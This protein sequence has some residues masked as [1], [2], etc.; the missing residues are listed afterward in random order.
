[1][2]TENN[3][4]LIHKAFFDMAEKY[5]ERTAVVQRTENGSLQNFT[6]H[7]IADKAKRYCTLLSKS[8]EQGIIGA[9]LDKSAEFISAVMGILASGRAYLPISAS[10]PTERRKYILEK[11]D[12]KTVI[13]SEED[14]DYFETLGLQVFTPEDAETDTISDTKDTDPQNDAY[15]IF[16]SGTTGQPKGVEIQHYA[17][18]NTICDINKRF[19]VNS[20]DTAFAVSEID[21]DLSVYDIFGLLSV[22]GK[23]VICDKT[24]KKEAEQWKNLM[25]LEKVTVWNSVPML[26]DMLLSADDKNEVVSNLRL[27][28]LSG[29]WVYPSLIERI[30][31]KNKTARIIALGGATEASIWSN[32][33]EVGADLDISLQSVP[34]GLPLTNQEYRIVGENGVITSAGEAGELQIGGLGLAKGYVNAPEL[35]AER[36]ITENGSRWY[37][38]GDKGRYLPDGNIEFLGRLDNQV[39]FGGYRIELDEI[40]KNLIS[41][42]RISNAGTVMLQKQTKQVLASVIVEKVEP[43]G[44]AP[45][46]TGEMTDFS[47]ICSQQVKT[48]CAALM[49]ILGIHQADMFTVDADE[50]F[51]RLNY[52]EQNRPVYD[53]WLFVLEQQGFIRRNGNVIE[54]AEKTVSDVPAEMNNSIELLCGVM[55]GENTTADMLQDEWLSPEMMSV[56]EKG[57][58]DGV[59]EIAERI[60]EKYDEEEMNL[61][62]AV[63]GVRTGIV[64]QMLIEQTSDSDIDFTFI[65]QSAFFTSQARE[66]LGSEHNYRVIKDSIPDDLRNAFDIVININD[67]HT[68]PDYEQ[69]VFHIRELLKNK[70]C[71]YVVDL[72]ALP[73]LSYLS[74][75]KMENGFVNF[76]EENR[77]ERFNPVMPADL[78]SEYYIRQGFCH[79]K[80]HCYAD[81]LFT[82]L[83]AE[84]FTSDEPLTANA[85]R[86]YLGQRVPEYM[87]PEKIVFA[88]RIPLTPNGKPDRQSLLN[89]V[90]TDDLSD[91][92]PPSTETE[93]KLAVMWKDILHTNEVGTEQSFFRSGGDS[94]LATHLLT[95]VRQEFNVEFSLK[96][97]YSDP[98][99]SA[100]AELIDRKIS[101]FDDEDIEFGEI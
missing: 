98:T 39:K 81:S 68:H 94:L 56:N 89:A 73:P 27:I 11:A 18:Y 57:I 21:F 12:V 93:K 79:V 84:K 77:P 6:Y 85:I 80:W 15:I 52:E 37:R 20:Q 9:V 75:A 5:P 64:A 99:L 50:L 87:I 46:R 86:Y 60:N 30:R 29:D 69:E 58:R 34:Y 90:N 91:L 95:R 88:H 36:F 23:I 31:Q 44:E 96:E 26:F 32:C 61:H 16:T 10:V 70:G 76:T 48:V 53:Y 63:I 66:R 38:T 78:A 54:S 62:I 24:M 55:R 19:E 65:D 42:E 67:M 25:K 3:A 59:A 7:E 82:M 13:T 45:V 43:C 33:Y 2:T 22:G 72:N 28:L 47:A 40:T 14:R 100:I 41:H 1:M 8:S 49:E 4:K 71:A 101:S 35:T 92:T 74:A 83:E 51:R 17:A 97:M